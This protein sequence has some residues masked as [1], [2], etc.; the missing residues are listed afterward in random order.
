MTRSLQIRWTAVVT[1]MVGVVLAMASGWFD[2][3]ALGSLNEAHAH[4]A[5]AV[6]S[7]LFAVGTVFIV[8]TILEVQHS[9]T[10]ARLRELEQEITCLRAERSAA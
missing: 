3:E 4:S 10:V 1:L 6:S 5:T 2:Q 9:R 8:L 7:R